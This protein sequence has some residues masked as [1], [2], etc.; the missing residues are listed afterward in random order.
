MA[1]KQMT[2]VKDKEWFKENKEALCIDGFK[3][4]THKI[5]QKA[6]KK[7]LGLK[8]RRKLWVFIERC[9]D[10]DE[11]VNTDIVYEWDTLWCN[12]VY[13]KNPQGRAYV[14]YKF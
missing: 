11:D 4:V 5:D 9:V 3:D 7:N 10:Y 1:Q 2:Y 14:I 13:G 12:G 6:T 8:T